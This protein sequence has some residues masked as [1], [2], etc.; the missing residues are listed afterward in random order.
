MNIFEIFFI[1]CQSCDCFP[2]GSLSRSC[3]LVTGQCSCRDTV[4]GRKCDRCLENKYNLQA[5]C[6]DCDPCYTLVQK[7]VNM[8]RN[9]KEKVKEMLKDILENP[10]VV[11][12]TTFET[13]LREVMKNVELF[14]TIV[15][16]RLGMSKLKKF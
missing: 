2:I 10:S 11:N 6:L 9:Q 15:P 12:D 13:K 14:S 8:L 16:S 5:G 4:E 3:D 1:G 7:R